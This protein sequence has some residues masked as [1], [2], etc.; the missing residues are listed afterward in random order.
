MDSPDLIYDTKQL[1]VLAV[2]DE[3]VM[4]NFYREAL[5]LSDD[6]PGCWAEVLAVCALPEPLR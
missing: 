5:Y 3:D 6:D 4:L 1:R 2:D